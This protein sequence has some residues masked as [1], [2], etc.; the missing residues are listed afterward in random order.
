MNLNDKT[1]NRDGLALYGGS[2]DPFHLGHLAI[3]KHVAALE[4]IGSVVLIPSQRSPLKSKASAATARDRIE[5]IT[6]AI[7]GAAGLSVDSLEIDRGGISYSSLTV[8]AYR[9]KLEGAPLYWVLGEDQFLN[10]PQW[11][12]LEY[13]VEQLIFLV[14]PRAGS[15]KEPPKIQGLRYQWL[16]LP[17]LDY[18]STQVRAYCRE[19]KS[20]KELVP[21]GVEGFISVRGLYLE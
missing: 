20:I 7:E 18:S 5:M 21:S 4:G 2:F 16:D 3:S 15:K 8:Q 10:L 14:I 1:S 12:S 19:L 13:L 11:H 9:E 6:S 17:L